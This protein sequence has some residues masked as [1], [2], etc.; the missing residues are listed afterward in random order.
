MRVTNEVLS[1]LGLQ[2]LLPLLLPS[3]WTPRQIAELD[4]ISL[5]D[6]VFV[7]SACVAAMDSAKAFALAGDILAAAYTPRR[8]VL[9]AHAPTKPSHSVEAVAMAVFDA[10]RVRTEE[11]VDDYLK[12]NDNGRGPEPVNMMNLQVLVSKSL[13][14]GLRDHMAMILEHLG[15]AADA[16]ADGGAS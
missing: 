5:E 15:E 12:G 13:A 1:S 9:T 7:L 2:N 10:A 8:A 3:H 16:P 14:A 4:Q 6:R 11:L